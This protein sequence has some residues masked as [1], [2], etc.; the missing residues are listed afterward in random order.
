MERRRTLTLIDTDMHRRAQ[1]SHSLAADSIHIEPFETVSELAQSWPRGGTILIHDQGTA[2]SDLIAQ[3]TSHSEWFPVVAFG[4]HAT[5]SQI[6]HAVLNGA[7]DY[8]IWPFSTEDL[9]LSIM[10]ATAR[11]DGLGNARMREA[12]AQGRIRKLTER[13]REVLDCVAS[14]L[15]NRL[16]GDKLSISPRTVEIHRANMLTKLDADHTSQAIRIAI[17]AE[18]VS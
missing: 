12:M 10:N 5:A 17:E 16:I 11:T 18:L 14:G 2:I 7:M 9:E 6:A 3:M 13:E 4:E 8:I 1:I 15:S